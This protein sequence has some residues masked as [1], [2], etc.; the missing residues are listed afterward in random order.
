MHSVGIVRDKNGKPRFDDPKNAPQE[1]KDMLTEGD[2][3]LLDDHVLRDLKIPK[4]GNT[5]RK[6]E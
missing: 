2:I 6:P 4:M 5:T 3:A 1:M